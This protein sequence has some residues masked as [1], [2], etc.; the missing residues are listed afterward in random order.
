MAQR[1][2][3]SLQHTSGAEATVRCTR[4]QSKPNEPQNQKQHPEDIRHQHERQRDQQQ[5][6]IHQ[7]TEHNVVAEELHVATDHGGW[8]WVH[9]LLTLPFGIDFGAEMVAFQQPSTDQCWA[10]WRSTH[11]ITA[12][13][14]ATHIVWIAWWVDVDHIGLVGLFNHWQGVE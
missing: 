8:V 11:T 9:H 4:G 13:A 10:T 12:C 1:Q 3:A 6:E 2:R 14:L 7:A 5:H